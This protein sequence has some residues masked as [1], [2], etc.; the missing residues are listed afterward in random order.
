MAIILRAT[1]ITLTT[2][3]AV[4]VVRP[5]AVRGGVKR[6][7]KRAAADA[8]MRQDSAAIVAEMQRQDAE[9]VD[10]VPLVLTPAPKRVKRGEK[11]PPEQGSVTLEVPL[12]AGERAVVLVEDEG[13]YRWIVGTEDSGRVKRGGSAPKGRSS[14]TF[15][16]DL[17]PTS[18]APP[19][20]AKRGIKTWITNKVIG[21]ATAY[22]FRF[23]VNLVGKPLVQY[24]ERNV[25]R[26]LVSIGSEDPTQWRLL[27]DDDALP[28]SPPEDRAA[29]VLLMIH[30]T[31]SSTLGSYGAL[32]SFMEGRAFL[33]GALR[34]YDFVLGFDHP[35][36]SVDPEVN[37][38]DLLKRL[39]KAPWQ[40]GIHIEM[41]A[42][43]AG[44]A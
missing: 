32:G 23:V 28:R 10:V 29:R 3:G 27:T 42:F 4:D 8:P 40:H 11:K 39:R 19:V 20:R 14:L 34:K 26:G 1:G 12:K 25:T 13:E 9:L 38:T 18:P 17:I 33:S 7:V 15:Q 43:S 44:R 16:I 24:L 31:F 35:T 41:V 5:G 37:A 22:V 2:V 6:G 30:G 36:L 21:K